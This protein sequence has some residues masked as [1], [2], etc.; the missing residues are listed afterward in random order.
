MPDTLPL[1]TQPKPALSP[2]RAA[3]PE[4]RR[5][6]DA[7]STRKMIYE[8]ALAKAQSFEPVQNQR[9]TLALRDVRYSGPESYSIADQKRAIL[10]RGTLGREMRGTWVLQDNATGQEIAARTSRLGRVPFITDRGTFINRGNEYT[11]A[12]Q[13]RLRGGAYT[14]VKENGEL[15]THVNPI[16]GKGLSHRIFLDPATGVFKF[17]IAQANIPLASVLRTMGVPDSKMREAWG[18]DLTAVNLEKQ[19]PRAVAKLYEKLARGPR[20][21]NEEDRRTAVANALR[22]MELDPETTKRTL[23]RS[24]KNIDED[25][26]LDITRKL[27]RVNNSEEPPDDRDSLE[28]QTFV[29][30]EDLI[31]ERIAKSRAAIRQAL[32]KATARGNLDNFP[33]GIFDKSFNAALMGSGLGMPIEEINPAEVFDQ[34]SRVTRMGEGGIPSLDAVPDDARAVQP[35]QFGFIDFLRTPECYDRMTEVMTRRGWIYWP[36]VRD[37]DEFACLVAGRLEYHSAERLIRQPYKG[38]MHGADTGRV[39]YLVTPNHRL[40]VSP[41]FKGAQYRVE[42]ADVCHGS[43]R[44]VCSGGFGEYRGRDAVRDF[45]LPQVER[46]SNNEAVVLDRIPIGPWAELMGWWLGEGNCDYD[47]AKARYRIKITQSQTANPANCDRIEMLL[48]ELPFAWSYADRSFT[49]ATKQLA[50]YFRQFGRS[51][52]RYIPEY[53]L[54]APVTARRRL[55]EAM[56]LGEGRRSRS[57]ERTQFCT[58]SEQLADGFVQLAFG[59][60]IATRKVFEPDDRQ[61]SNHGGAWVVHVHKH[62]E[63]QLL[64]NGRRGNDYYTVDFDDEVFCATVPGGLLYVRR[65]DTVGH[66]SGNSG[67]VGVDLRMA[68]GAR[69]GKDGRI[70]TSVLTPNFEQAWVTPQDLAQSTLAFPGEMQRN[71]E[72]V[73]ALKGGTVEM[74]PREEVD[75]ALLHMEDSFSPLGN[76]IPMKSMVKGQRA[77][78]AAR[79]LTQ[80]LPLVKGEAP[81]VQS[82]LPEAEGRSFEEEYADQLG[83]LRAQQPGRVMDVSP[84]GITV[85]YADGKQ[86]T[87]EL[88]HN[89]PFNRKTYYHQTPTV[90]PGQVVQPGDLLARSN[91]TNEQGTAALGANARVAYIPFRGMNFEDAIVISQ[92]MANRLSS[93]HMYQHQLEFSDDHKTGRRSF[94]GLFPTAYDRKTLDNFDED[95]VIKPGTTVK[96]GDPLILA[97]R[98]RP[99]SQAQVHRGRKPTYLNDS[100]TWEHHK[101][102][103][104]TDVNYGPK[105]AGVVVKAAA[106]MEEGDKLSGRYGDKGVVSSIIPDDEMPTDRDGRPYEVLLNP[107]GIITRCYD[108]QTE[109]LTDRGWVFGRD[110]RPDDQF[111][112][113]QVWTQGLYVMPQLSRFHA[114]SYKGRML[115]FRNK[116]MDFCVTPNHRMWAACGYPGAPWQEVTAERIAGRKGWKVPVAGEPVPGIDCDFV[117]PHIDYHAKDTQTNRD[118]IV[119]DAGDWAEFLGWYVAEGNVDEKVH[120]SQNDVANPENCRRIA[121]LL[122]RLPFAWHYSE[123]NTQFHITSK[124]L[125]E[126]VKSLELGLSDRKFV[127]AWVFSQTYETR[128]RFLD[129]Y[130]AGDGNKDQTDRDHTYWGAGTMSQRLAEDLQRLFIYQGKSANVSQ[131]GSGMWRVG[132][133][134]QRHRLLDEQNWE[135]ID[136]DGMIYCPTVPTGYVVTRRNGKILFA[137]NTNPAQIVEAA[138]GKVAERTGKP[139][140]LRDFENITDAVEYAIDELRKHGVDDVEGITDPETHRK[141]PSIFTGNRWFMK[142]H[143][144]AE[145]KAQ[146]RGLGAYTAEGAPAKG[147]ETGAKR[148]GMLELSA[149]LSHGATDVIRDASLV[150]GQASPEYWA[151]VMAGFNPPTPKVPYVYEKFVNQLKAS[152]INVL[153][154]GGNVHI[155]ALRDTDIDKLAGDREIQN[156]DTVDWRTG[157]KPK[158]GG[159]FDEKLTGGHGGSRWSFIKLHEPMPNPVMEEPIRRVLGLTKKRMEDVIAGKESFAGG[160]GPKAIQRA[161]ATIDVP[162]A[163]EQ[164][165][166]DIASGKTTARDA[167]I[168]RLKYLKDTERLG[169]HPKEWMLTK[170]PV[171]PPTFRPVST[172]GPKK[173]PM[174]A[175]PNF[176]YKELFDANQSLREMSAELGDDVGE[177]RLATYNALRAVTGLGDPI[178]PRNKERKVRGVLKHVFGSSPK[179]GVV[180]RRL[181]GSSVDLVGRSVI[182]PNPDLDMDHVG[183]PEDKAWEIYKPFI[184]RRLVRGGSERHTAARAVEARSSRAREALNQEMSARPVIINRAPTLHRYGMMAAWPRLVKGSTLQVSPL[185]VGGFNADF[186]GDAMNYH[187]PSTDEAAHEAA[188]KMLPSRNLLSAANFGVLYRPSQEYTGGLYEASAR[189]DKQNKPRVFATT[190][191]AIRAYR[192]GE[193][194]VDREVEIINP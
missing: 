19:D 77:V 137:G 159:L 34:Q 83:A 129:G 18:N 174:V 192:R 27:L 14:R 82:G 13:M 126:Y 76:M 135:E 146:G 86:Q 113:Y 9:Y 150:R 120:I 29:G 125:C 190:A 20:V 44:R 177:E 48:R 147:G 70:Y 142:L 22:A 151:Q 121:A 66:W 103:L 33:A 182:T 41:M 185:V 96:K 145:G 168:R 68:R 160:T 106:P 181:L 54:E 50:A 187:V 105:G 1:L 43:F 161:L 61:R 4:Y 88:Y 179:V 123:K 7:A 186:D 47:E 60:G 122:E 11:L 85:K 152:G 62:N 6:G 170:A 57:G 173:L 71:K 35:S 134:A 5:F 154:D 97:A 164:A 148:I 107:L 157:L 116:M 2:A 24:Y 17:H 114:A 138:L 99:F 80:A 65:G 167:A 108:E 72:M 131:Q 53:L 128:Q 104:V 90:Q 23:G 91:Y 130:L 28:F 139:Y 55:Y 67:K 172:M 15:E 42:T 178:H 49:L 165:R 79:M 109:F 89:F 84:E 111:V 191:D 8:N 149:L 98:R 110:V 184:V 162:K 176:L 127:P 56:L 175:D 16:P 63:H 58:T 92:G 74:V 158:S 102:G 32:W 37:D 189:R 31:A 115:Q 132:I 166:A 30:P 155:M 45:G 100:I 51:H 25:A 144:M 180:Q 140:K 136:Y 119:V 118:E 52:E 59:L 188:E 101:P 12:H 156:A 39:A 117:L 112:C 141:I 3:Q 95:G 36:D 194:N 193:I 183:I 87:H 73:A 133:H 169:I 163:I 64:P 38:L 75:Y 69:K 78:M 40:W 124:R 93:E 153:R 171:L 46:R 26:I 81:L 10:N 21:D 94:I 143:H